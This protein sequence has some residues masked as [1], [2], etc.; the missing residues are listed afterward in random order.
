MTRI[1]LTTSLLAFSLV[2]AGA[3]SAT[4][5]PKGIHSS[6]QVKQTCRGTF[7][8][9]SGTNGSYGCLNKNGSGIYCGGDTPAQKGTCT[10]ARTANSRAMDRDVLA[11]TGGSAPDRTID[12]DAI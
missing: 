1:V 4:E 2:A 10:K 9:P 6:S 8:P 5:I 3:A 12:L 7:M 11:E